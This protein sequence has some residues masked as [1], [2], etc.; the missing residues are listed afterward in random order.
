MVIYLPH[1]SF[2]DKRGVQYWQKV[3]ISSKGTFQDCV[4]ARRVA[5]RCVWHRDCCS[6][7]LLAHRTGCFELLVSG[8]TSLLF[9]SAGL[10]VL[11]AVLLA[12]LNF[13]RTTLT[14]LFRPAFV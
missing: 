2:R 12:I 7:D 3:G 10:I 1:C 6:L 14:A 9:V 11:D 4:I 8:M 13:L 5:D